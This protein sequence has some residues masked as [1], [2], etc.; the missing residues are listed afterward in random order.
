M[1]RERWREL[2]LPKPK[3]T[4]ARLP[5]PGGK[6]PRKRPVQWEQQYQITV[7][8]FF[9]WALP[10][11]VIWFH[12]PNGMSRSK[13]DAGKL[14]AMGVKAGVHDFVIL[15]GSARGAGPLA[16][17]HELELKARGGT[18][19]EDQK[20]HAAEVHALGGR[21][22]SAADTIEDVVR[23]LDVWGIPHKA[24]MAAGGMIRRAGT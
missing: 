4:L 7:A 12:V 21:T 8:E 13:G 24:R 20:K 3:M 1:T 22:G 17:Y 6:G 9:A 16:G 23:Q 18:L 11:S 19:S 15:H 5:R 14:K 2:G 10:P